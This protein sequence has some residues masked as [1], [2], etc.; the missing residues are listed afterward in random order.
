M[1]E[2]NKLDIEEKCQKIIENVPRN[3][4]NDQKM[5]YLCHELALI[6]EKSTEFFYEKDNNERRKE[7]YNNYKTIEN[8]S[9]VCRNAVYKH[10]ELAEKLGLN[11]NMI[12]IKADD[13]Q[14]FPHWAIEYYGD[15]NKRYLIN[16]IPD[17]YRIQ[18]G[19]STKSFC[20]MSEYVH[21]NGPSFD[22]MSEEYLRNLDKTLGYLKG[23]MYTEELL[24]KLQ[25]DINTKLGTHI[26]RTSDIYQNYNMKMLELLKNEE[27]SIEEKMQEIAKIDPDLS[28]HKD[29]IKESF[30][31]KIITKQTRKIMHN[32]SVKSLINKNEELNGSR[33]GAKYVGNMDVT[34]LTKLKDELLIYRF[35]YL[36]ECIPQITEG[37]TGFIENKNFMEEI[38]KYLFKSG[39]RELVHRHTVTS[40]EN[41]QK[42]YYMMFSLKLP[43]NS[44]IYAFYNPETKECSRNIEPLDFM[45]ENKLTPL[46]DSSLNDEMNNSKNLSQ[47]LCKAEVPIEEIKIT[48]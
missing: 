17:F 44:K 32:L 24:E 37:L 13:S 2:L 47:M 8:Y 4:T 42:K 43:D 34:K 6:L 14:A 20:S 39:E 10:V 31:K 27:M 19:F 29:P 46:K 18:M 33:D 5:R 15:N 3:L 36:L 23:N 41:S 11:C 30:E 40:N 25:T 35:N 1:Q 38:K 45:L 28:K 12:E 48:K 21:Y 16:P 7:I 22:I 26:V 9:V